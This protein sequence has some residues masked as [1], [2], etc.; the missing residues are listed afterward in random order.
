M[1][2]IDGAA[3][4]GQVV[5]TAVALSALTGEPVR[6]E[7]VR[8][9]RDT[10]G[11]RPQH[12]AAVRAA[13]ALSDADVDGA[14][15]GSETLTFDP[16]PAR[17]TDVAVDVGTAGSVALVLD[18]V[19]PLA[20]ALDGTATVTV[21]GGTDVE[22]AP[23]VAYHRQ[24]KLPL[25]AGAGLD[26]ELAVEDRGFYPVGGG[27][28]TLT[29]S[30]SSLS[31]LAFDE[32]GPLR[33]L[34]VYSTADESL[35]GADVAERQAAAA[36]RQADAGV[37]LELDDVPVGTVAAYDDADS[38]GSSVTV[39]A[40]YEHTRAGFTALG[41]KGKP[42]EDVAAEA[43][44][45]FQRF[46]DG[47]GAVDRHMADQLTVFQAVAGGRVLAPELTAHVETNLAVVETF[48][49]AF[50]VEERADGVVIERSA[51]R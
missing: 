31:P 32:R 48:G 49:Y 1:N 9:D 50:D 35:S 42:S 10:P 29:L 37:A 17:A 40:V 38:P 45:D 21:A 41:E 5:R 13:A 4:G 28:V 24:V 14:E 47:T 11:L 18:A 46:H 34:E 39:V 25:L 3:G 26:A 20:T 23:P 51:S 22:W 19:L 30:P 12:V 33:R 8:G 7:N 15:E 27:E 6:V 44:A 36:V 43:V 2:E 16:G